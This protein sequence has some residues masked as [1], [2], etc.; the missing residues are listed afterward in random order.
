[1]ASLETQIIAALKRMHADGC[2]ATAEFAVPEDDGAPPT[3]VS[4]RDGSTYRIRRLAPRGD[5]VARATGDERMR[6]FQL[7]SS[8][9]L[10][11]L[12][13]GVGTLIVDAVALPGGAA[14]IERETPVRPLEPEHVERVVIGLA[15][16]HS[17][18]SG[19][20]ARLT[21]GLGLSPIGAWLTLFSPAT[22]A[23]ETDA[24]EEIA[25]GWQALA[26]HAPEIWAVVEPLFTNPATVVSDLRECPATILH[27]NVIP[28]S[29][30]ME[31]E[32]VI[33]RDWSQ[34]VRGPGALDLWTLLVRCASDRSVPLDHLIEC[35]RAERERLGRLPSRGD[36]WNRELR[37]GLLA[38]LMRYG[39]TIPD[40]VTGN[41]LQT[42][43]A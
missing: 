41:A 1:M 34:A 43:L 2:V 18:F 23:R 21:S 13:A 8:G 20:P 17:A 16:L 14:L 7:V 37:L 33:L 5:W 24:P 36:A 35:Y 9:V 11:S 22:I 42:R 12:P 38:G 6:A 31:N 10:R 15:R 3:R 26:T 19:F 40:S 39:W 25:L 28:A 30:V 29:V 27:G 32:A 4:L